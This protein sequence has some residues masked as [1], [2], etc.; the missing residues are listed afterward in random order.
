MHMNKFVCKPFFSCLQV[1]K[2]RIENGTVVAVRCLAL[3]RK[4]SAG[5]LKMRLDMLSKLRHPHL[6]GLLGHCIEGAT[7]D[8]NAATH[9]LILVQEYVPNGNFR[10][11]LSGDILC[12]C[13]CASQV[14]SLPG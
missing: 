9:R 5:N 12:K 13:L 4:Y 10:S 11:H 3:S 8:N 7:Q 1:Y 2:G 6:V 14:I